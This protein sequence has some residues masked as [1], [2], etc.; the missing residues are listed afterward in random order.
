[1]LF[2][3]AASWVEILFSFLLTA[4]EVMFESITY[5]T[6]EGTED[7]IVTL[8]GRTSFPVQ[9]L[10]QFRIRD[11]PN[12]ATGMNFLLNISVPCITYSLSLKVVVLI[13]MDLMN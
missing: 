11:F 13:T 8:K 2:A 6:I 9:E 12:T 4:N 5:T 1:M 3:R 7:V 10:T